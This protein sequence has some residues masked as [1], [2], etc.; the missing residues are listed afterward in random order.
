MPEFGRASYTAT[1]LALEGLTQ[2]L[3]HDLRGRVAVNCIRIDFAIWTEGFEATLPAGFDTS[4]FEDAVIMSDA[5]R[6]LLEQDLA[7]SG[8]ILTLR[9][10]RAKGVVRDETPAKR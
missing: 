7:Y 9:E 8:H 10:L 3:G 5:V 4:A 1:K 2:V 6:W